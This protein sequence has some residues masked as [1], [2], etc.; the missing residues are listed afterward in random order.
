[1]EDFS[2]LRGVAQETDQ[3]SA[4]LASILLEVTAEMVLIV[5]LNI[6]TVYR[7]NLRLTSSYVIWYSVATVFYL[8]ATQR[9]QINFV[10]LGSS[11][12]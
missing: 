2:V 9:P 4:A 3:E 6:S 8:H 12:K 1:V 10:K 11:Y 5:T 7:N